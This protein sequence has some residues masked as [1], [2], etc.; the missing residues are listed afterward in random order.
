[1]TMDRWK[2]LHIEEPAIAP[3]RVVSVA[4]YGAVGDGITMNTDAFHRAIAAC[5]AA[6]GGTVRIP[7]GVWLTGSIALQSGIRLHAERGALITFSRN[8]EHYPLR[9]AQWEG[10][11]V[12]RCAPPI[13]G[14]GLSDIAITGQG[15][16]DGNGQCWRPVKDWKM[17]KR[18][19]EALTASGGVVDPATKMWWPDEGARRGARAVQALIE[20]G[21]TDI[22][23]YEPYRT[24]LRPVLLGLYSCKNV[25]LEGVTF[26]NSPAWNVHLW[27]CEQVTMRRVNV[28]NP[29]YAQNGD[30][31]DLESCRGAVIEDCTFDVGDDAICMK[32]GKD[33]EGRRRGKP[34]EDVVV[35]GC[36]VYHGHG[37]FVIG[38]EMSGDVR[39]IL[40]E[41]C[42][43]AG[44]DVGLRFKS[45]RGRGGVVEDI[46]IR[47]IRMKDIAEDAVSF[48]LFYGG[49]DRNAAPV[50]VTEETPEI[51]R[52]VIEDVVC[53]GAKRALE[54]IGLPERPL[55]D[56]V[57]RRV[58]V[59]SERP[60]E[61]RWAE[62]IR[63][64]QMNIRSRTGYRVF[65][66]GDSTMSDYDASLAPRAGWGQVLGEL[67]PPGVAVR[68]HAA[69]GR[70]T[71]SFID[72]GRLA[73]IEAE[74][75]PGDWLLIQFGH[76]D[77]KPDEARRTEP[78][79]SYQDNLR[80][81]IETARRKGAFP[82]LIT[83]VQRRRFDAS[84]SLEDT[85]GDY[86]AAMR[87]Q[88]YEAG[89]PLI[90]LTALSR[91]R[92]EALGEERTKDVFLWLQPGE[93][94][95]YP[96]GV[97]D[98]THFSENGAKEVARLVWQ[99]L[100]RWME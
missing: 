20:A 15:I 83:P 36:T 42:T 14:D 10:Q 27:E 97:Q 29:W 22:A 25:L 11:T 63:F 73:A 55:H 35:R 88:A 87:E 81:Y 100:R 90:D 62:N 77:Q 32:S 9:L 23:A 89:V 94:P 43:F 50:A 39:R 18:Q 30:G 74:L 71:K 19:W 86:P 67:L 54:L 76:N 69:S 96:D 84:G 16:F 70:S 4:D 64:E 99:E 49:S 58:T 57:L 93:H 51:R 59:T 41:D 78:Y 24:F 72:E 85:H 1:M 33:A 5:A 37:G 45:A 65:L 46:C 66:A 26:Q 95:N 56:M 75:A 98:N 2:Q 61:M 68:N 91:E 21:C 80:L 6:G 8:P 3:E 28:R 48:N 60:V 31:L 7:P 52:I 34:T 82:V 47:R 13:S 40:V 12:V 92:F 53:D 79:G 17:T 44:T 38:S